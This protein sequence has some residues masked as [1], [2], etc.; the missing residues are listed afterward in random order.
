MVDTNGQNVI[1]ITKAD[2][3]TN[4]AAW[5]PEG[6][7]LAYQS[8][9]KGNLD[10]YTYDLRTNKEYRLTDYAGIDSGPTWDC[11]GVNIA[12]TSTRDE[13]TNIFQVF[14]QGGP[15]GNM[16]IHPA[17]DKWSQWSPS[18]ESASRGR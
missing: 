16:T 3:D 11:G 7:R 9:R 18:K 15:S 4:N 10:I 5:S 13:T 17:S 14:W 8:E 2:G 6:F 1:Q 12:Y